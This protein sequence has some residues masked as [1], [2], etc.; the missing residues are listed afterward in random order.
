MVTNARRARLGPSGRALFDLGLD[1]ISSHLVCGAVAQGDSVY[2]GEEV[3]GA[4]ADVG[5]AI[6]QEGSDGWRGGCRM[7]SVEMERFY[8]GPAR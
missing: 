3:K 1:G 8:A 7:D 4:S 5:I 2:V 6:V